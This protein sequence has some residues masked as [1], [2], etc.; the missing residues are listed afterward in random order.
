MENQVGLVRER[1]F[2][3]RLHFK[4]LEDLNAWL[5]DKCIAYAKAQH[6]VEQTDRTIWQVFEDERRKLV[7]Y[8]GPFDGFHSIPAAV[9]KTCLVRFD[10][11]SYSVLSVAVGRPVDIHAYADR[12]VIRQDGAHPPQPYA[13]PLVCDHPSLLSPRCRRSSGKD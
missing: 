8:A 12:I 5:L 2:T 13:R 3:P 11:N 9:S 1:F 4:S 6:H 7:P 10:A